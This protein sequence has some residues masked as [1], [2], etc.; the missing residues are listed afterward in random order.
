MYLII[1]SLH[2]PI[3]QQQ[4]CDDAE[5]RTSNG[6]LP[7]NCC[8]AKK[9]IWCGDIS[10]AANSPY[11]PSDPNGKRARLKILELS[12]EKKKFKYEGVGH[13][14]RGRESRD[15]I[16]AEVE[17]EGEGE[18]AFTDMSMMHSR[19]DD[20]Y[21][22]NEYDS[23]KSEN[24]NSHAGPD[25]GMFIDTDDENNDDD[26][27]GD[28]GVQ[29]GTYR[30]GLKKI[31]ATGSMHKYVAPDKG[32]SMSYTAA[33]SPEGRD[34][35]RMSYSRDADCDDTSALALQT[36]R[37]ARTGCSC[38]NVEG[39]GDPVPWRESLIAI[40]H[41]YKL[42]KAVKAIES[43]FMSKSRSVSSESLLSQGALYPTSSSA[44]LNFLSF[45]S[46]YSESD[47]DL[48]SD[49]DTDIDVRSGYKG[50]TRSKVQRPRGAVSATKVPSA[51]C[52]IN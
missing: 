21:S 40:R 34:V 13:E 26:V 9:E 15:S 30:R 22:V 35:I 47:S 2:T 52:L 28:T 27:Q 46:R 48:D 6:T 51:V 31:K 42:R 5:R 38:D 4:R 20:S 18:N 10:D 36:E 39:D 14:R 44:T 45:A 37:S 25:M 1:S 16:E 49:D 32:N 11:S 19:C 41:A 29:R 7:L 12:L 43:K 17:G 24:S 3:I 8:G 23:A 33:S 50:G